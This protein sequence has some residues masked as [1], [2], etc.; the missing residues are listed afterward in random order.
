MV[1]TGVLLLVLGGFAAGSFYIPFKKVRNWAWESY[2][3][4]NGIFSWVIMPWL[5]A[6]LTVPQLSQIFRETP[7]KAMLWTFFFGLLW[8]IGGLTFGLSMRY[9]GMS[10]GY[11]IAL[12]FCAAFGTIAPPVYDGSIVELLKTASGL[13]TLSG[14]L[15]CLIGIAICGWAGI[16]KEREMPE[17]KKKESIKEFNF[18]RGLIVAIL[19]GAMSACMAFGFVAGETT[20]KL[21]IDHG[22]HSLWANNPV[23]VIIFAGGFTTNFI[24][25][26]YLNL[27]N[28]TVSNYIK[29]GNTS[30]IKNYILSASAGIIWYLQF[31][32]Y[33]MGKTRMGK[34][35]FASWSVLMAMIIVISN[36]WGIIFNE[37]KGSSKRTIKIIT[38]GI[39]IVASS[40]IVIGTGNY[41]A[42]KGL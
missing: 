26:V 34:Y 28:K 10:L 16:T 42:T 18:S 31:M 21:A 32:F 2:W 5:I 23:L 41:L 9:L 6:V 36:I 3:L 25:C 15:V 4:V 38:I 13:T 14:V 19:A 11:A 17:E 29:S 1:V 35:D 40:I 39:L 30:L 8:G 33:G 27:K 20:A 22:T 12:G 37:W 24:W 7:S